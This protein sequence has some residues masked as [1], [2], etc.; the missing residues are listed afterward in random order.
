MGEIGIGRHEFYY[1][2]RWWE[3]RAIVRGYNNR[4][5]NLW[6][7]TRWQTYNIMTAQVGSKGMQQAHINKPSDL[8]EF[9]WDKSE[10]LPIA[11][12]EVRQMQAEM[13]AYN[14][15]FE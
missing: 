12:D 7:A 2:L 4:Y 6:S 14:S 3:V 9:P 8:I 15:Q 1:E 5:R 11:V 10:A 13:K